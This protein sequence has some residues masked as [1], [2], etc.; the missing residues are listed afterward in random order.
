MRT[1]SARR[2]SEAGQIRILVA[3]AMQGLLHCMLGCAV[4]SDDFRNY[5]ATLLLVASHNNAVSM[6]SAVLEVRVRCKTS[7]ITLVLRLAEF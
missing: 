2:F 3:L 1:R 7:D 5:F 6:S 4:V